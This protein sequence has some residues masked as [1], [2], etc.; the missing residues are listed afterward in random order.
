[1]NSGQREASAENDLGVSW[2]GPRTLAAARNYLAAGTDLGRRPLLHTPSIYQPGSSVSHFTSQSSPNLLMEPSIASDL[3]HGAHGIDITLPF[4]QDIGWR[5]PGCNNGLLEGSEACD[6]GA[7]NSD[8]GADACRTSCELPICGDGATDSDEECDDGAQN[9]FDPG[10]CRPGCLDFE[11]GDAIV[12]TGE[13]C[14]E[15]ANNANVADVCRTYCR[16]PACGDDILDTGEQCDDGN[17]LDGDGCSTSCQFQAVVTLPDAAM[18]A[19]DASAGAPSAGGAHDAGGGAGGEPTSPAGG[20][21]SSRPPAEGGRDGASEVPSS[22][23]P[24]E[25]DGGWRDAGA[26]PSDPA[27]ARRVVSC[28]CRVVGSRS[29]VPAAAWAW[30]LGVALL[31]RR[32]RGAPGLIEAGCSG[33]Q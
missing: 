3:D 15:G 7:L 22:V 12:D 17:E 2:R 24:G 18:P 27:D 19:V 11:C 4:L 16:L 1:M 31:L 20:D 5:D 6:D 13:D 8:T 25:T 28:S 26:L 32:R 10:H 9:S 21:A 14:D 33:H 29:G 30:L 23:S